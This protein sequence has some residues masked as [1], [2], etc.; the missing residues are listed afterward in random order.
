MNF[1]GP[2]NVS[3]CYVPSL[4][5]SLSPYQRQYQRRNP[6][7]IANCTQLM[8]LYLSGNQLSGKLPESLARL[9]NL[10]GIGISDNSLPL[11]CQIWLGLLVWRC[12]LLK[13]ISFLARYQTLIF[14]T[15][16]SLMY[17]S[18]TLVD[19]FQ[20][21]SFMGNLCLCGPPLPNKC[22]KNYSTDDILMYSGY[23]ILGLAFLLFVIVRIM[24]QKR[25][26][27]EKI[28]R[29]N[30]VAAVDISDNKLSPSSAEYK[31]GVS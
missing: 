21:M 4:A 3:I 24:K 28:E 5:A 18:T 26:E 6:E 20:E 2:L 16:Y 12:F 9:N 23:L 15:F 8:R 19:P 25:E 11:S 13:T 14:P 10:K 1:A 27:K 22:P 30:K 29:V 17:P 7:E 31:S